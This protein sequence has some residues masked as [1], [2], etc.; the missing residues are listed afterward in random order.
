[1]ASPSITSAAYPGVDHNRLK[2]TSVRELV[3]SVSDSRMA[4][5]R[6]TTALLKF[7]LGLAGPL[8]WGAADAEM[9][10][11]SGENTELKRSPF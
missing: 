8:Q 10:V 4:S 3:G 7:S 2:Y 9:K 11:P 6:R 1:M 5:P